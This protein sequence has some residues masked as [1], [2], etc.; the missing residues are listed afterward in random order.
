M[1]A[2][3][4]IFESST[5]APF[6]A[7]LRERVAEYFRARHLSDKANAVMV[8]RTVSMLTLTLVPYLLILFGGLPKLAMLGLAV[9]MGVGLAGIGFGVSHDALH[10]AYSKSPL[11]NRL[12][13]YTFDLC[14]ANGYMWRIT[15]NVIHHTYTNIHGID[16]DLE[17]SPL[18]RLSPRA[19]YHW[20]HRFQPLYA[21]L[22]YS[23]ST[24]FWVFVK[25]YKYFLQRDLGPYKNHRPSTSEVVT[26]LVGKALYY[27]WAIVV[28]LLVLPLPWWQVAIGFVAMN[29]TGGLILG[30]VFQLAHVVED[31]AHPLPAVDGSMGDV[32]VAHELATTANFANG[33][34]LITW[35]VGGLNHQ[36]EHHLF[37]KV[38]SV[39]YPA[40]APIVREVTKEYGLPYHHQPTLFSAIRSHFRTL[41]RNARRPLATV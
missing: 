3:R 39:H 19:E 30:V 40:L 38:C 1:T 25:D 26:L 41:Q 22:L 33:N 5:A 24:L 10:G 14:G 23:F 6:V 34:P 36:I 15:H 27:S 2:T 20:Y 21:F 31:T 16:E 18:L 35:Y 13:G 9:V 17:V 4:V 12:I 7:V 11:V 32:W 28:P 37:P 29:L 8:A